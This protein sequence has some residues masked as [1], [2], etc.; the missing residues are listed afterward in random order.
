M[1]LCSAA[2][3]PVDLPTVSAHHIKLLAKTC[4][5]GPSRGL[6]HRRCCTSLQA[7]CGSV[8]NPAVHM[9]KYTRHQHP[10]TYKDQLTRFP[11]M[12]STILS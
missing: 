10:T 7:T 4:Q 6:L 11:T 2:L 12:S 9:H 1:Q 5:K 8:L 3:H